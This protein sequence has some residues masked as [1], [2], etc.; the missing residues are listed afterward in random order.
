MSGWS[1]P[2]AGGTGTV[3]SVASAD[4]SIA[5]T[6]P[7]VAPTLQLATL[8]VVA[9]NEKPVAAVPFNGQKL[10]GIANGTVATDAAAF[11]QIPAALPTTQ[12]LD[13]IAAAH[14]TAA[15]WSN[16]TKKITGVANGTAAGDV[17]THDQVLAAGA[18][19]I[20]DLVDPTAGK[21]IGSSGGV[22]AA[23]TPPGFE[24]GYDQRTSSVSIIST[25]ES[26]GT[27]VISAAAHTFDG[28]AV[29]VEF[30]APSIVMPQA[31]TSTNFILFSLFEGATQ[32]ARLANVQLQDLAS[33]QS[34]SVPVCA[35]LR[36]T[37]TAASH[38]YTVTAF[39]NS[40]TGSPGV[41]AGAG[42]TG[43]Y[44]PAF[45]RFTKV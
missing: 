9:T 17:L 44:A 37:P 35:R 19:P 40:T 11:G 6:N 29:I 25:T 38:T 30:F 5:V 10:T 39:V 3:T 36:F 1:P 34:M 33:A 21:V 20:A 16:N 43:I 22:A 41:N 18:I 8:D 42:G 27:A 32:I 31:T 2:K 13:Q 28:A 7:T 4:T 23:V 45:L 26:A 14:A 12:S 15:D 24:I